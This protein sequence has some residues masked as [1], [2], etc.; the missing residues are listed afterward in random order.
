MFNMDVDRHQIPKVLELLN[1]PFE[2]LYGDQICG[3]IQIPAVEGLSE[4]ASTDQDYTGIVG[5]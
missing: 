2:D 1:S 3:P 5:I 4:G